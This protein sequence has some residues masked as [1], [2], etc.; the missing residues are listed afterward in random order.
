[1]A[2][3]FMHCPS[4]SSLPVVAIA[5]VCGRYVSTT[6]RR[7]VA[8]ASNA[9]ISFVQHAAQS[10]ATNAQVGPIIARSWPDN[11]GNPSCLFPSNNF[12]M[13][14][15]TAKLARLPLSAK[16]TWFYCAKVRSVNWHK[17]RATVAAHVPIIKPNLQK[18][19][20]LPMM[21]SLALAILTVE[22]ALSV[23]YTQLRKVVSSHPATL[24]FASSM[25]SCFK[26]T[27]V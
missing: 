6:C 8:T 7:V 4:C 19:I 15:W 27:K 14:T 24:E 17:T 26:T 10:V 21:K 20:L 18:K 11:H 13:E 2:N 22:I 16:F 9:V 25:L 12:A 23:C 1:M 5:S 3:G